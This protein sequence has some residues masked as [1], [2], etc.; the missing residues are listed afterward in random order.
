MIDAPVDVV[1]AHRVGRVYPNNGYKNGEWKVAKKL[2]AKGHRVDPPKSRDYDL[3]VDG[4]IKI[5]VKIS[6]GNQSKNSNTESLIN[7]YY[8]FSAGDEEKR[9]KSDFFICHIPEH[10]AWFIIPSKEM[11]GKRYNEIKFVYPHSGL[12]PK[13]MWRK[14]EDRWDLLK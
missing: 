12:G 5:D 11:F 1:K 10:N 6:N 3:L 7:T 4:K 13:S 8:I 2:E 9:R 14:Y